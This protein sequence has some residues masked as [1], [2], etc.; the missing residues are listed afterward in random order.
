MLHAVKD[1]AL[2]LRVLTAIEIEAK[3]D[4][5]VQVGRTPKQSSYNRMVEQAKV[6]LRKATSALVKGD[7]QVPEWED[8]T[9]VVLRDAHE[10]AARL[11]RRKAGDLA[12]SSHLDVVHA[13]NAMVVDE[14]YLMRFAEQLKAKDP[15][16]Y[17]VDGSWKKAP[18]NA[19]LGSYAQKTRG[20]ANKAFVVSSQED[21]LFDWV[22][23]N[24]EHCPDCPALQDRSPYTK[25]SLPSH[26]GDGATTCKVNCGCV[27]VRYDLNGNR[28]PV[29][30]F[31]RTF[32]PAPTIDDLNRPDLESPSDEGDWFSV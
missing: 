10:G 8:L 20:T 19:R 32:D 5:G 13:R 16:Y 14:R 21:D 12:D 6:R 9:L 15:R 27:L 1:P 24:A 11:G 30:G 25:R 4:R 28:K 3:D 17:D 7:I 26:P 22:M 18:I 31:A 29:I 23:L 2:A